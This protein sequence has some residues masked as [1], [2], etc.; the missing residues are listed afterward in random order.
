M[1][2]KKILL[3]IVFDCI[4]STHRPYFNRDTEVY[5][6]VGLSGE[7]KYFFLFLIHHLHYANNNM[8]IAL[9]EK[10]ITAMNCMATNF[11]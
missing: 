2:L 9:S 1:C 8:H 11:K 4:R 7:F 10:K 3:I 6:Y 5:S